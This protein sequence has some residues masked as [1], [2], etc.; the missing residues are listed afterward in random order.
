MTKCLS[1]TQY[2]LI[3][4]VFNVKWSWQGFSTSYIAAVYRYVWRN[5][6]RKAYWDCKVF[7]RDFTGNAK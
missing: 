6:A 4:Q 3:Y 5:Y 7:Y 1:H 2:E